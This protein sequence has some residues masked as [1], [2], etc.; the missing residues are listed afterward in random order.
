MKKLFVCGLFLMTSFCF[1]AC[2]KNEEPKTTIA[3]S[4]TIA[5]VATEQVTSDISSTDAVETIASG[6]DIDSAAESTEIPVDF[7]LQGWI[8]EEDAITLLKMY[9]GSY[10]SEGNQ[11]SFG[12]ESTINIEGTYYYN[13][14]ISTL[15]T[16]DSGTA[17]QSYYANYIIS[18]DGNDISDYT[19]VLQ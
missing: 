12:H 10:D 7:Q 6:A 8:S 3:P 11:F 17:H 19:A 9:L 15:I 5:P 16:D 13:F 18:T 2:G 4:K 14:R 1:F